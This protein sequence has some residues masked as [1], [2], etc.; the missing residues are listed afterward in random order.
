MIVRRLLRGAA[1]KGVA[2]EREMS[3]AGVQIGS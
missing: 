2:R 3:G 1:P